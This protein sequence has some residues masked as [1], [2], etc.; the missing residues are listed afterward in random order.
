[1]INFEKIDVSDARYPI[2]E[3][4]LHLS[5]P[6]NERRDDEK[7]K[8][9]TNCNPYFFCMVIQKDNQPCGLLTFW[10]FTDFRYIEHFAISSHYRN[11]GIG[12]R[13]LNEFVKQ[14]KSPVVLEVERP[15]DL[16]S[17]RRIDFYK[18]LGFYL[19]EGIDYVQPPYRENGQEVPMFLMS[20][21]G[22]S[23]QKDFLK[24]NAIL[25]NQVYQQTH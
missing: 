5:F 3:N 1:M 25:R 14:D 6:E 15:T 9:I 11:Q 17:K 19:W 16:L 4:L 8:N 23:P 20:T 18:R 12:T 24:V 2:V 13:I 21:P 22:L 10:D 7:Q